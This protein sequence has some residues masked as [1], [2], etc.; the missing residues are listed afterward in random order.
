MVKHL[1][2]CCVLDENIQALM[3][4]IRLI[5]IDNNN[6]NSAYQGKVLQS[7]VETWHGI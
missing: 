4:I 7:S 1:Y 3:D 5:R 2:G 6:K